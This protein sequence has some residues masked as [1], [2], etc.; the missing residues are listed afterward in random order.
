M[1]HCGGAFLQLALAG[2][3]PLI[4]QLAGVETILVPIALAQAVAGDLA[5][6]L[7]PVFRESA[8]PS[9]VPGLLWAGVLLV[10]QAG[11]PVAFLPVCRW[12]LLGH[13]G[14]PTGL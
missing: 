10:S 8:I 4:F 5:S 13:E 11:S 3:A 14:I 2:S 1:T 6:D 7:H 12:T 9:D